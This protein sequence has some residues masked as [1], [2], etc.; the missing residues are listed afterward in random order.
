MLMTFEQG[1]IRPPSEA[2]SLLIRVSRNCPWNQCLFCPV[3]KEARFS[4]RSRDEVKQDI[5]AMKEAAD[6]V[7]AIAF[8]QG[9]GGA[10]TREILE[11]VYRKDPSLVQVALWLY[12]GGKN[13]FLQD[14][15]S[16]VMPPDDLAE[17]LAFVCEQFPTV[18]RITTYARSKTVARRSVDQLR[19]LKDAGLTRV[20][21][22]LET[23]HDPLLK[24]MRKGATSEEHVQAGLRVKEAG[25][26]LSEY[27]ILGLGGQK[28]W[29]EHAGDTARVLNR[30]DPHFIRIRTLAL[31][32]GI[33]LQQDVDS[34][35]FQL[36]HDDDIVCEE[37]LLLEN[38]QVTGYFI[39]DHILNLLEEVEGKIPDDIPH[40]IGTIDR[41]LSLP[42]DQRT[43]F[44]LGRRMGLYRHLGDMNEGERYYQVEAI[45]SGLKNE[46]QD[47]DNI[48]ARRRG[49]FI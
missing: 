28:L 5:A 44:R 48:L 29:R 23:G 21:I 8:Q 12:R 4:K 27:V 1:P 42:D 19:Q 24:Y 35:H 46:E 36:M 31:R 32:E 41:Y 30:I 16:L 45:L 47:P 33:P 11:A 25:L 38:L 43:N 6:H 15:D 26:S 13:V 37:R 7:R 17:I 40:M 20:H 3:Y 10:V 34:G 39:S 49:K 14:A 18:E 9:T 22:G 2:E